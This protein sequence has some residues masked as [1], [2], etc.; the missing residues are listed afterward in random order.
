MLPEA[1]P[2]L[3]SL[4]VVGWFADWD[5]DK[6]RENVLLPVPSLVLSPLSVVV[7]F[8]DCELDRAELVLVAEK[9][10]GVVVGD[11]V[12]MLALTGPEVVL[13]WRGDS[14]SV[15]EIPAVVELVEL[16]L[17]DASA[18]VIADPETGVTLVDQVAV[19]DIP[20]API[21]PVLEFEVT[22]DSVVE[23]DV[24]FP[25][26]AG[27]AE[28]AGDVLGIVPAEDDRTDDTE[29]V[30]T[31]NVLDSDEMT[32]DVLADEPGD[33]SD[34]AVDELLVTLD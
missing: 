2:V 33:D 1:A 18:V 8:E 34:D 22:A 25:T 14:L 13:P 9:L 29:D 17:D 28:V 15:N 3:G 21:L 23:V 4:S 32:A 5:A 6:L 16:I 26:V 19:V 31:D 24:P 11:T 12:L 27:V 10:F 20:D 7:R 30:I